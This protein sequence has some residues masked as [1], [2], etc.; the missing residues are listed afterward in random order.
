VI[1]LEL[2]CFVLKEFEDS[3]GRLA[4]P[5]P[6][7]KRILGHIYSSMLTVVSQG[8]IQNELEVGRG[9]HCRGHGAESVPCRT[10]DETNPGIGFLRAR[11][12]PVSFAIA[13]TDR[14]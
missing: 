5:E 13:S 7:G 10:D 9:Y 6:F 14:I 3:I 12:I 2:V 8:C 1:V 4:C 11:L